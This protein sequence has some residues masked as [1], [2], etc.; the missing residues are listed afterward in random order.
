ME[1][2][3]QLIEE[4]SPGRGTHWLAVHPVLLGCHGIGDTQEDALAD[5]AKARDLWLEIIG[6][7]GGRIPKPKEFPVLFVT[8][9]RLQGAAPTETAR[10]PAPKSV[11][12]VSLS[13]TV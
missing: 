3:V 11:I 4:E 10:D 1:Y 6:R 7:E 12:E 9:L 2:D 8:Y 5:L 13:A